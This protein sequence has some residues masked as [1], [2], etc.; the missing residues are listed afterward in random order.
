MRRSID[1]EQRHFQSF[2]WFLIS[3]F[4]GFD[5]VHK[6]LYSQVHFWSFLNCH[7]GTWNNTHNVKCMFHFPWL[8][9]VLL[10]N[11]MHFLWWWYK[12]IVCGRI[13]TCGVQFMY[14]NCDLCDVRKIVFMLCC[15]WHDQTSPSFTTFVVNYFDYSPNYFWNARCVSVAVF[16]SVQI[17]SY[18]E[19]ST[20]T[21]LMKPNAIIDFLLW[22]YKWKT[23]SS[24][25]TSCKTSFIQSTYPTSCINP[26]NLCSSAWIMDCSYELGMI[27][28]A[29][30]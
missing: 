6:H 3:W 1:M 16:T 13:Q 29:W 5:N 9:V 24:S 8:K 18:L 11:W 17:L 2:L 4:F 30:N 15:M 27:C 14:I 22:W 26:N 7:Y 28:D 25:S 10:I 19:R 20:K 21:V 23:F 12:V